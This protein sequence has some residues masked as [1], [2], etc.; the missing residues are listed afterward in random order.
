M[1]FAIL[2][3][4]IAHLEALSHLTTVFLSDSGIW[5]CLRYAEKAFQ[6]VMH[7]MRKPTDKIEMK[8][9]FVI[10]GFSEMN[11]CGI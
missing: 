8:I 7:V 3:K 11:K 10:D 5:F 1:R 2:A 6:D 9:I 4:A